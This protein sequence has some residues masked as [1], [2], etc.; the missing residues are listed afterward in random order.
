M[1]TAIEAPVARGEISWQTLDGARGIERNGGEA[2][3]QQIT[4]EW[5]GVGDELIDAAAINQK[6]QGHRSLHDTPV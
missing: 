5:T 2:A 1:G 3:T 6:G 4:A